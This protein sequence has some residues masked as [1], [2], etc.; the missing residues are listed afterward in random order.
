MLVGKVETSWERNQ[1]MRWRQV[2][3]KEL[4]EITRLSQQAPFRGILANR[5]VGKL[6]EE[7]PKRVEEEEEEEEEGK[8]D[9]E[10]LE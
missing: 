3:K 10:V 1:M 9:G 4:T 2:R 8:E 6:Q 5:S 7:E